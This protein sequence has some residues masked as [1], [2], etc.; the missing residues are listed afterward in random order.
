MVAGAIS[1]IFFS[2]SWIPLIAGAV[3]AGVGSW[4]KSKIPGM[5]MGGISKGGL[6]LVGERGP[7][8]VNLPRG[9]RVH[10]NSDSKKMGGN[11]INVHIN[12]R[13][14]ASDQEIRD[15]ARKVGAQINREINRTTS[16]GTR[17]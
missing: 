12:G 9:S 13:L 6:T 3:A 7:E 8:L 5:A 17:M 15:I 1:V 4:I 14:G 2:G 16:S 11:T 10:S